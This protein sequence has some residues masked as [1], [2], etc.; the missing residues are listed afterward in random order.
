MVNPVPRN[1]AEVNLHGFLETE[2]NMKKEEQAKDGKDEYIIP[3]EAVATEE[4]V[5]PEEEE[6]ETPVEEEANPEEPELETPA[7]TETPENTP[8]EDDTQRVVIDGAEYDRDEIE[9]IFALGKGVHDRQKKTNGGWDP[10]ALETDYRI[11]T[12]E[13]A[14]YKRRFG[15]IDA[16]APTP[17]VPEKPKPDISDV[18]PADLE[19]FERVLQAKGYVKEEDLRVREVQTLQSQYESAKNA[20][21][22]EFLEKYPQYR[23]DDAAWESLLGE[24]NLYKVPSD[25]RQIGNLLLRAH[26]AVSG[27]TAIDPKTAAKILAQRRTNQVAAAAN[28]GTAGGAVK[29]VVTKKT[30]ISV[31]NAAQYLK[32]FSDDEIK[33]ILS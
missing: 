7:P 25:P 30:S 4:P 6:E 20:Q 21:L 24:Y 3:P 23:S 22:G 14:D 2:S 18:D 12:A 26:K 33:E 8:E 15:A 1:L 29:P 27:T 32:G 11:K 31:A 13:L 16:P 9:Q 19:R 10:F 5:A 17:L 28:G